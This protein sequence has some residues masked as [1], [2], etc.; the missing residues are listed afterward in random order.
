MNSPTYNVLFLCAENSTCSIMAEVIMN[1]LGHRNFRAFSAGTDPSGEVHPFTLAE[2][3]RSGLPTAACR[4]KSWHEFAVPGAPK[5]DFVFTLCDDVA[6]K[7]RRV[8]PYLTITGHWRI[9]NPTMAVDSDADR[10]HAFSRACTQI[11]TRI[12][13]FLSLPLTKLDGLAHQEALE[14]TEMV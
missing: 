5:M 12:R 11:A 7:V 14:E 13:L 4:S 10:Q 3:R 2:L 1:R 6:S 8:S 9:D